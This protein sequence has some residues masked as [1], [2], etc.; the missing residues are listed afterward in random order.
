MLQVPVATVVQGPWN[1]CL[2]LG[3]RPHEELQPQ[4]HH[5]DSVNGRQRAK[6]M[7]KDIKAEFH[8]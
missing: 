3:T 1:C 2:H 7:P 5:K 6:R 4:F 8:G